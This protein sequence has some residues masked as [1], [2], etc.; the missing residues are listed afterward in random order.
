MKKNSP[1]IKSV[2]KTKKGKRQYADPKSTLLNHPT[3]ITTDGSFIFI[4]STDNGQIQKLDLNIPAAP[5]VETYG[6]AVDRVL[7]QEVLERYATLDIP[8]YSGFINP[9]LIAKEE[10]GKIVDVSVEYPTDFTTQMLE[11][12]ENWGFLPLEN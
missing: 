8:P 7:H 11:Y 5:L 4:A 10:N 2:A 3:G 9:K 6:I 12:S 1:F